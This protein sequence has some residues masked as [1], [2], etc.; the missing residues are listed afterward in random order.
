MISKTLEARFLPPKGYARHLY[1]SYR[2][3]LLAFV[4]S[5]KRIICTHK[6]LY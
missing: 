4:I 3:R 6:N 5:G 2:E 1:L